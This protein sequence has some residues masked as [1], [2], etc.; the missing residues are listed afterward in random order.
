M[1][2]PPWTKTST[3]RPDVTFCGMK[4]SSRFRAAG[5]DFRSRSIRTPRYGYAGF[6]PPM[7]T[8]LTS[9]QR[10]PAPVSLAAFRHSRSQSHATWPILVPTFRSPQSVCA[11]PFREL[12]KTSHA[13]TT[14]GILAIEI[15]VHRRRPRRAG[16][17]GIVNAWPLLDSLL[18]FLYF[19]A[20]ARRGVGRR[21][22]R[23]PNKCRADRER[24]KPNG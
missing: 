24:Q 13:A 18:A 12:R 1:N 11:T 20:A 6:R 21:E 17:S 15:V 14:A 10:Q 22:Y 23:N 16:G 7:P 4:M 5:P 8:W 3:G 19:H 2:A 9:P